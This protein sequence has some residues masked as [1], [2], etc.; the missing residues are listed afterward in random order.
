MLNRPKDISIRISSDSFEAKSS[1]GEKGFQD[2]GSLMQNTTQIRQIKSIVRP[3]Y[4]FNVPQQ[5]ILGSFNPHQQRQY[6]VLFWRKVSYHDQHYTLPEAYQSNRS[7]P[8]SSGE[9]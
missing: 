5:K 8:L 6:K 4:S 1:E 2:G 7:E 3:K 9:F